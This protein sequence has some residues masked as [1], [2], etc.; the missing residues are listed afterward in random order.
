MVR[1]IAD[2]R[3]ISSLIAAVLF[4]ILISLIGFG[5]A[6]VYSIARL[7]SNIQDVYVNPFAVSNAGMD[8]HVTLSQLHIHMLE[9]LLAKDS[10][11]VEQQLSDIMALDKNLR[12]D[13]SIVKSGFQGDSE[14]IVEIDHLLDDWQN[15]RVQ[16]VSLVRLGHRDQALTLATGGGIKLT[17]SWKRR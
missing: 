11:R 10:N 4:L 1:Q 13:F 5:S 9:I 3:T 14:K 12:K 6:V 17:V 16:L 15:M 7:Q 8:A 2:L